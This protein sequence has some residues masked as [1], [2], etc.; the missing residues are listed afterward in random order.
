MEKSAIFYGSNGGATET[1]AIQLAGKIGNGIEVLNVAD[2]AASDA[3]K[4]TNIIFGTSTWGF[5]DLQDDW[6]GF[7]PDLAKLDLSGKTIALFGLGDASSYGDSFVDGMGTI[8][9]ELKNKGCTIVGHVE[10]D[11][12]SFDDSKAVFDGKFVGLP[13]DEDNES[14][15]TDSRI[16][17]WLE[18]ITPQFKEPHCSRKIVFPF[19]MTSF[20]TEERCF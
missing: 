3:E 18:K 10:T 8:Y 17:S 4:Y 11:G 14:D 9:E 12:Y 1:I 16:D 20:F 13:L 7:L 19:T 5:G 15:Q 6:E 2:V